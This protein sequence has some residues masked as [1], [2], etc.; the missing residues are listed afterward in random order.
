MDDR[1][2]VQD[3]LMR[4]VLCKWISKPIY[5]AA[6]LGIADLL[7]QGPMTAGELARATR[8]RADRLYRLLRALA[9]VGIFSEG[10]DRRFR[11]TPMASLLQSRSMRSTALSFNAE[12]ND[13]AWMHLL[14]GLRRECTPFEQAFGKS[15]SDWL[16]ENPEAA[17]VLGQANAARAEQYGQAVCE[18]FDFSKYSTLTDLGGGNGSLLRKILSAAPTLLG[19]LADLPSVLPEAGKLMEAAGLA[20][21]C[22]LVECDFL[23]GVPAGA[24]AYVLANVL[25]DW[26]DEKA[27]GILNNC[28]LAMKPGA[29]LLIIEMIVPPGNERSAAKLLDLEM[30]VVTGGRE[31]GEDEFRRLLRS[32]GLNLQR[33]VP[34]VQGLFVLEVGV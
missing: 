5:A 3:R 32:A 10:E 14:E 26:P 34:V 9:S 16:E 23:Q 24:D 4:M 6:E 30:M 15:L 2:S 17:R 33:I 13:R 11:L 28:R 21:R 27:A 25:H 29:T 19:T 1:S 22:N 8:T 20:D 12:W 31:R 7:A 18:I